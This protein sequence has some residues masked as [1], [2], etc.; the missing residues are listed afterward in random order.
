MEVSGVLSSWETDENKSFPPD[1]TDYAVG[2]FIG[3]SHIIDT[4]GGVKV[5]VK[6]QDIH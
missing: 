4:M 3:L 2:D 1:I 6:E 5:E